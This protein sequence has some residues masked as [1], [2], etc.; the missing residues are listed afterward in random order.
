MA[1]DDPIEET[2]KK[3][4]QEL[5]CF[6]DE[7]FNGEDCREKPETRIFGFNLLVFKFD[8]KDARINYISNVRREDMLSAMQE[9]IDREKKK[10]KN[11]GNI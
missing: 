2:L 6:L 8:D 1:Q 10:G 4:M 7:V 3:K 11:D 5:A 9:F